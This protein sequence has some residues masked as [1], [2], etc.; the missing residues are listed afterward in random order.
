M[1]KGNIEIS[2]GNLAQIPLF[3]PLSNLIPF[4]TLSLS[5]AKTYFAWDNGKMSFPDLVMKGPTGR[6]EGI[7]DYYTSSS[8]LDF[9]VRVYLLRETDIPLVSDIIMPIFDPFSQFA[10]VNLE[11]TLEK[12]DWGFTMSPLNLFENKSSPKNKE[13]PDPLLEFEFR[14]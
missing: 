6:L 3:G 7:G 2:N 10:S 13:E 5:D 4:T 11:G 8:T 1:A 9:Q 12:P 14:R